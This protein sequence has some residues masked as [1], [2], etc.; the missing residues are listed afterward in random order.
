MELY[1]YF[2]LVCL[3]I[4]K[5]MLWNYIIF[6]LN[7]KKKKIKSR[8]RKKRIEYLFELFVLMSIVYDKLI[9]EWK[10]NVLCFIN[11]CDS[12]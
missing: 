1:K 7:D 4:L 6:F 8:R 10:L 2:F 3:L 5:S 9:E 11:L 12:D